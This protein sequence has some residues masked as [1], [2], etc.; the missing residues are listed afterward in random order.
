MH[1]LRFVVAILATLAAAKA[2]DMRTV[3]EPVIPVACTTLTAHLASHNATLDAANENT[4][5]TARIQSA[6]DGCATGRAVT[7][8]SDAG[9]DAFLS[10]P[11]QLRKGVTLLVNAGAILFASRNPRDYDLKP[12]VC[13]TI[14]AGGHGCKALINGDHAARRRRYGR[15]NH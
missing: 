4:P 1:G 3:T 15:W 2:Q 8:R 13:G 14:D 7:L 10:G 6:I 11:L 12:G 5:D 9:H